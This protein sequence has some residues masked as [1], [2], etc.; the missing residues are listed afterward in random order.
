MYLAWLEIFRFGGLVM[1]HPTAEI[2]ITPNRVGLTYYNYSLG[3]L[4]KTPSAINPDKRLH[5]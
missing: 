2:Y 5:H 4:K 1:Y 3:S